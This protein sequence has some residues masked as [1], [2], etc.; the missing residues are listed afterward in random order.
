MTT[1]QK[2]EEGRRTT[3]KSERTSAS[4]LT[5]SPAE[6]KKIIDAEEYQQKSDDLRLAV[7][8][9]IGGSDHIPA[10]LKRAK[11]EEQLAMISETAARVIRN[12]IIQAADAR[13]IPLE[14]FYKSGLNLYIFFN[15]PEQQEET[16]GQN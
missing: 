13:N 6:H 15:K 11:R 7:E 1:H 16:H 5:D 4:S 14:V 9:H 8:Y 2:Q 3:T 12:L 10:L